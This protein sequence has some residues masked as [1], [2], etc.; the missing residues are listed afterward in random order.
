MESVFIPSEAIG[1]L[2]RRISLLESEVFARKNRI[3]NNTCKRTNG[4]TRKSEVHSKGGEFDRTTG[5]EGNT[6]RE[7]QDDGGNEH[8]AALAEVYLL[9]NK[10]TD[11]YEMLLIIS[12]N[13][14][15]IFQMFVIFQCM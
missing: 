15:M 2:D 5:R 7:N 4:E 10:I 1:I 8:I 13:T 11:K 3:E 14:L 6:K 9:L 12:N